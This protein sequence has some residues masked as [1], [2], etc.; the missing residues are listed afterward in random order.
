MH[1]D[2]IEDD[3]EPLPLPRAPLGPNDES[4]RPLLLAL[5]G[6]APVAALPEDITRPTRHAPMLIEMVEGDDG[7]LVVVNPGP[8]LPAAVRSVDLLLP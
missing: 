3:N 2:Y 1:S 6:P 4:V 7:L 5:C 8:R